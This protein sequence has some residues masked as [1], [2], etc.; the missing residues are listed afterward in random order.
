MNSAQ[1]KSAP[2]PERFCELISENHCVCGSA[3][4]I[5]RLAGGGQNQPFGSMLNRLNF[6]P[7]G[8]IQVLDSLLGFLRCRRFISLSTASGKKLPDLLAGEGCSEVFSFFMGQPLGSMPRFRSS[9]RPN[10]L[11]QLLVLVFSSMA[12]SSNCF[13]SSAGIRIG[14]IGDFPPPLGCLSL[15]IDMHMPIGL[16]LIQIGIYTN[17]HKPI[18]TTPRAAGTVSGRLTTTLSEVTS[19]LVISLP[20]LALKIAYFS[21]WLSPA[22]ICRTSRTANPSQHPM[23][24][25]PAVCWSV[26]MC[27]RLLARC[28]LLEVRN[29]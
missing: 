23:R 16:L 17:M 2:C 3:E 8:F 28:L 7:A 13:R 12:S 25:R 11:S 5:T 26:A 19:W 24:Q 29:V 10:S 1:R 22:P 15:L 21:F 6:A 4:Y 14:S 20:K 9:E 27:S 18:M